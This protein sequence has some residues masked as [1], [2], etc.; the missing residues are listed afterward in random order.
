M[1]DDEMELS[2]LSRKLGEHLLL[3][4]MQLAIYSDSG[5][6]FRLLVCTLLS[7]T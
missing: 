2:F 6:Y 3:L 5:V 1:K 4:L 7:S